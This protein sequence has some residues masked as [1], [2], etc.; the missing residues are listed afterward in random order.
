MAAR[1]RRA[2]SEFSEEA[3]DALIGD[4]K[5]PEDL[6]AVFRRMK[7]ALAERIVGAEL[8]HHLGY[9]PGEAKPEEQANP[10]N[11]T[12]PKTVLTGDDAL[13]LAIPRDRAGTFAPQLVPKHVRRLP[14]FDQKV[15]SLYARALTVREIQG[16]LVHP[17]E[18]SRCRAVGSSRR[19]GPAPLPFGS[20]AVWVLRG[21][22]LASFGVLRRSESCVVRS[23][24][25][26]GVLRR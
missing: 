3:L 24:A 9:G 2:E 12:T 22:G 21:S 13:T 25:S 18:R 16:H 14:R 19:S 6:D 5:T 17:L 8:T 23:L 20:C 26:F 1:K 4:A 15:L 7:K 11:G 10:R